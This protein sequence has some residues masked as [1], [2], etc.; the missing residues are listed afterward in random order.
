MSDLLPPQAKTIPAVL[1]HHGDSRVD[2]YFWMRDRSDPDVLAYLQAENSYMQSMMSS[3]GSLQ[4]ALYD[5]ILSHIVEDD[6]DV[7]FPRGSFLYYNRTEKGKAYPLHCRKAGVDAGEHIILDEN[8]L[9]EGHSYFSLGN[10]KISSS[11]NLLA[12]S[13]DTEGDETYITRVRNLESGQ[14]LADQ[15]PETYYSLEWTNDN[16]SFYYVT[17][18]KAKRPY[19]V[20]RHRLGQQ[21][22][23]LIFEE[24]DERFEVD[25]YQS[26][27]RRFIFIRSESKITSEIRF[28]PADGSAA[29]QIIWPRRQDVLYDVESH[30]RDFYISTND[31]ARE[32]RLMRCSAQLPNWQE[33]VEILPGRP[34]ITIEGVYAFRDFL[35]IY[36]RDHGLPRLRIHDLPTDTA[37]Y[38]TFAEPAF[39]LGAGRNEVFD[40]DV[41]R[42]TYTSLVTPNSVFEYNVRTRQQNLLKRV[43][44][45]GYDPSL[46]TTERIFAA[47][48]DGAQVPVSLVYRNSTRTNGPAPLLLYGYG[49]YGLRSD[50]VFRAERLVLLDRGITFAIAHIRGG[51]DLGR[52]W[53]EEGKLLKKKNTFSDFVACAEHLIQQRYTSPNQL[54][55]QGGSAG[56]LLMG[57]VLNLRPD[58]FRSVV[59]NVPFVDTLTTCLDAT[60]PLTVGEYEEWGNA[61]EAEY[62]QYIKSYSPYDNV[63]R[64]HYPHILITAGLNDPRVSYWEPAKWT[65]KLR[66]AKLD[67]NLLLL[68]TNMD[69]GHF[70][71]SGRYARFQEIALIDAFILKTLGVS[72]N[73]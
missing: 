37:H 9:A 38:V 63:E 67:Q 60:L 57:A 55:I 28:A 45:P 4:K 11:E 7:P 46:Y 24:P 18:N 66:V 68:K 12:Y 13:T 33:A 51:G 69:A 39:T 19:R 71:A 62:Y 35:V 56:G 23:E 6:A 2:N 54:A 72:S 43:A 41:F 50:P 40:T 3:D 26:R 64:K 5:E 29:F 31:G 21:E 17:L 44:V 59:A 70:G 49:S 34:G 32:F 65:A 14:D 48:P 30:G 22:N 27:D 10:F 42:F 25:I 47:A 8:Q 1:T 20:W 16:A 73:L 15:V 52:A 58:L 61:N 36:E 53:Y